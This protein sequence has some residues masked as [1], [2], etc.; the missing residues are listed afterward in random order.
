MGEQQRILVCGQRE[1]TEC[2]EVVIGPALVGFP[3]FCAP[4]HAMMFREDAAQTIADVCVQRGKH[5]TMGVLEV[6]EHA[7]GTS[8][9]LF[10]QSGE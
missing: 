4:C 10:E 5:S 7:I 2:D 9:A 3:A 8:N 6:T 1:Q